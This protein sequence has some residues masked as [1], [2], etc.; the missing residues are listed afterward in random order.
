MGHSAAASAVEHAWVGRSYLW[1]R[2]WPGRT[3]RVRIKR[4]RQP[5]TCPVASQGL[6]QLRTSAQQSLGTSRRLVERFARQF[7]VGQRE[8]EPVVDRLGKRSD[9]SAGSSC[10]L[11]LGWRSAAS[12]LRRRRT[13]RRM[14]PAAIKVERSARF[15]LPGPRR[16]HP[17]S[18]FGLPRTAATHAAR[19]RRRLLRRAFASAGRPVAVLRSSGR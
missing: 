15:E 4:Q 17:A 11:G 2:W 3:R 14:E 16:R 18:C 9:H 8:L 12:K 6:G 5:R 7:G 10:G 13:R 1:R 19:L